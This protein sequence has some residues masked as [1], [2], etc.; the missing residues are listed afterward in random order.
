MSNFDSALT[1]LLNISHPV[2]LAP[3]G[4]AAGGRLAAAV[5]RAGGLGLV[6]ASYGDPDW[7][8]IELALMSDVEEP[9]GVGLVMFTVA[10]RFELLDLALSY[11]PDVV[12]LSFGDARP[13]IAP[14]K[15]SGALAIVQVHDV[16]QALAALDAGADALI[17]QGA[18]AG[19]HSL[20]RASLPLLP[21][22][23]DAVGEDAVLIA[24]G[25]IADGRGLAAAL[26]LGADGA[27]LGTRFL[28][29]DEALPSAKVKQRLLQATAGD[30]VRTR[31]FDLVRGIEWPEQ[32]SGR[33]L[34]NDFTARWVGFEQ[35]LVRAPASVAEDYAQA[36]R[37]DNTDVRAIWTGEVADL[38]NDVLPAATIVEQTV[39]GAEQ[40]LRVAGRRFA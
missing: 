32:Y 40:A 13:F 4:G 35:E 20:R 16:D 24:A 17:V 10:K 19:G 18:E 3:M 5:S 36:L 12:A 28:A 39:R 21:A 11:G 38:I 33:A 7:M 31:A 27:M 34:A 9:W 6:G 29:S 23:R 15:D 26:L 1:R 25:G 22:V 14:I 2:V 30:L 8:K 37:E